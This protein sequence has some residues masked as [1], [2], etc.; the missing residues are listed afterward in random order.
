MKL[1]GRDIVCIGSADWGAAL[2]TNQQHLMSRLAYRNRVVFF[3]SL[4]LRRPQLAGRDLRRIGARLR[5]GLRGPRRVDG[6]WV[7]SPLVVPYHAKGWAQRLNAALLKAQVR[8]IVKR[9]D[10]DSAVLWS[11]VPQAESVLE[12]VHPSFVVYH[13]VDEIAAHAGVDE[14]SFLAAEARF[15]TRADLVLASAEPIA[16]RLRAFRK[17]VFTVPNVADTRLFARALDA[18]TPEDPALATL[19]RPRIVFMGNVVRTK[20]D[21]GLLVALA[22][23]RPEW[24]IVLVG[25]TGIGDPGGNLDDL[26]GPPNI[27]LLG[28]RRHDQLPG[29]LRGA[30]AALIPY[31]LTPLSRGIFPMKVYEYLAA[32]LPVVSTPLPSLEGVGDVVFASDATQTAECLE[33]VMAA[34]SAEARAARSERAL[35]HSWEARLQEIDD[36]VGRL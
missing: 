25:P 34:D 28:P 7:V 14:D 16:R 5:A 11:Y 26:R 27:Y 30:D 36:L 12:S 22:R 15:V 19:P 8:R 1:S 2:W 32:G 10:I 4:G 31:T 23:F 35:E 33:R 21:I 13:C 29:V 24:S 6:V 3:E 9:F 18:Q 20:L 17:D